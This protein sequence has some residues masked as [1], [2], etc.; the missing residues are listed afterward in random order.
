MYY[1]TVETVGRWWNGR[2][3]TMAR[4]DV[5]L[6]RDRDQWWVEARKGDGDAQVW[7]RQYA[8]EASARQLVEEL[9]ARGADEWKDLSD[10][11]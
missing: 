2:W 3:G 8:D 9:L 4:R 7:R 11:Y 10:L 6:K 1:H 5:W